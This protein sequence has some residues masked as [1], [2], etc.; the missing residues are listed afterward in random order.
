VCIWNC[1]RHTVVK[2]TAGRS[3]RGSAPVVEHPSEINEVLKNP[4][5]AFWWKDEIAMP[6]KGSLGKGLLTNF[7][8]VNFYFIKA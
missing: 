6:R 7:F 5:R 8:T 4:K 3:L 1:G 2:E